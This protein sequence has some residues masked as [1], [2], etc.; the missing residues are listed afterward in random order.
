MSK[1]SSS[2]TAALIAA[3]G[4][5]LL[6]AAP[7]AAF[8]SSA[9]YG[10]VPQST[11]NLTLNQVNLASSVRGG[12]RLLDP[13]LKNPWGAALTATS[14][15]WVANQ[16]TGSSTVYSLDPGSSAISKSSKV[17][18]TLAGSVL[19]PTG[20]V[21]NTTKGFVL[22]KG[23]TSAPAAFIWDTID[24]H[25][26]AW[27]PKADPLEGSTDDE[28]T[29][30]G[31]GYTGLAIA[32]TKHGDE[33]FAADFAK[34]AVDVFNSAFR[35]VK[36]SA[37]Q[38][39]DPKLPAG[40]VPF[41]TQVLAGHLFVTYDIPNPVTHLEGTTV[42]D[43]IVD[44]F[45]TDGAFTARVVTGGG[46]DAPWGLAIAPAGWGRFTG[47]LLV[48][49]F[50]NG[51]IHVYAKDGSRFASRAEGEIIDA[52]TRK[53]FQEQGLWSL[54]PGTKKTGGASA[55]WFT[56]GIDKEKGGLLGVLRP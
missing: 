29:V 50:G 20:V 35:Q 16:G 10:P 8:A 37:S 26:E 23:K 36:L 34:G 55:L 7:T 48:G 22:R 12:A 47:A 42:G 24:G 53:P 51:L 9:Q 31:A 38:F 43:G 2:R 17:R 11:G 19:G 33:L 45:S 14:P 3:A 4:A 56:A 18:V 6:I 40:Y 1:I 5:G 30:P 13:D 25:I 27:S 52:A 28:A 39:R 44:E 21:A 49:N 46:L 54:V 41:N 32:A 15:L